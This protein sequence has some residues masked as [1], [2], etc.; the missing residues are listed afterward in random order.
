M[1]TV[2]WK[3]YDPIKDQFKQVYSSKG[4]GTFQIHLDKSM[5]Y[6]EVLG[7]LKNL[8]FPG[9]KNGDLEV[10]NLILSLGNYVGGYHQT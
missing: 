2:D 6:A 8:F 9:G 10:A 3:H 4:G 7:R 1:V 5:T